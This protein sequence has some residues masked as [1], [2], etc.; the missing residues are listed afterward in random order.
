LHRNGRA[1]H[2][3]PPRAHFVFAHP[4]ALDFA[5]SSRCDLAAATA[6]AFRSHR[7]AGVDTT[8]AAVARRAGG[9]GKLRLAASRG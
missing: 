4:D 8:G 5:Q 7:A 9:R 6:R 1:A 2:C 3:Y